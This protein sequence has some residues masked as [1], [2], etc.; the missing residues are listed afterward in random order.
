MP[1]LEVAP[2][3][4]AGSIDHDDLLSDHPRAPPGYKVLGRLGQGTFGEVRRPC[5]THMSGLPW[6]APC[7]T[8]STVSELPASAAHR[9]L[10]S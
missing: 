1:G 7:S 8:V 6:F 5:G 10:V 2:C 4:F 3:A 9:Q